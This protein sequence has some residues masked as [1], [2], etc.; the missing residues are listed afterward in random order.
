MSKGY[1][2]ESMSPCA[3]PV[4]L[5]PKKD[6]TWRMCVDCRS[7]NNITVKYGHPIPRLDDKLDELYS[8]CIFSKIDLKSGKDLVEHLE[9]LKCVLVVLRNER[10]YANFKKYTFCMD[11]IIFLGFVVSANGV[12]VDEE[13]ELYSLVR[14]LE[15]WQHYLWPKE[16]VIHID[17]E[18]LKHLRGQG[19]ENIVAVAL[20]RRYVLLTSLTAKLLGFEYVKDMCKNDLDFSNIY[21]SCTERAIDKFFKYEGYL[22]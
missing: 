9:H 16:F 8:A 15:T 4:L 10:L 21:N 3:V 20:S 19:K 1:V 13:N 14:A 2:R 22:F 6:G 5:V 12:E 7:I 11:R 17:H 18:S